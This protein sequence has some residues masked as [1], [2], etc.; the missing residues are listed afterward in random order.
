[1][2]LQHTVMTH[3]NLKKG[4]QVFGA[5]GVQPKLKHYYHNS[6][7]AMHWDIFCVPK[8]KKMWTDQGM[9]MC[10]WAEAVNLD[11]A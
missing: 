3:L 11:F 6:K 5:A 10:Q 7:N 4:I 9:W 1:M 2:T 8:I